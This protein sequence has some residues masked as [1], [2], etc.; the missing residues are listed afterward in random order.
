MAL[1]QINFFT[2]HP[3]V[4]ISIYIYVL[5]HG[6]YFGDVC[7]VVTYPEMTLLWINLYTSQLDIMAN[8]VCDWCGI[9]L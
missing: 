4:K 1:P 8:I 7:A 2:V 3:T 5:F 9:K 6:K